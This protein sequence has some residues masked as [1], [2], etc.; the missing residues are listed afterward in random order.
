MVAVV[1]LAGV[2]AKAVKNGRAAQ[3]LFLKVKNVRIVNK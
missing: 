1:L 2:N 3:F